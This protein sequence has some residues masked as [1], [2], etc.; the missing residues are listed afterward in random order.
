MMIHPGFVGID[1]CKHHL[2][3]FDTARGARRVENSA[4]CVEELAASF[5]EA[6]DFVLFE[7]TGSYDR[8]LCLALAA[9][10]VRHARVNPTRARA[11]AHAAGFLAKTDAVDARMLAAM[12]QALDPPCREAAEPERE[13]LARL[14]KRRDQLVAMRQMERTRRSECADAEIA[15]DLD[16]H[17]AVLDQAIAGLDAAIRALLAASAELA[18]AARLLRS[19]PGI[20]PVAAA[21]L[22]ALLPELGA[23][24]PKSIAAL[25]GVAPLNA[26]SGNSRG[27]RKIRGGRKRVRDALYMAAVAATRSD[28]AL[29]RFYRRLRQAGHAP[30]YALIA[31]ARK[32]LVVANAIL[33]DQVPFHA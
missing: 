28:T 15:A 1:V 4:E 24:S 33:R 27:K 17:L 16:R 12:A 31:L 2:D 21:T 6:G 11:F 25:V 26:D 7:A 23:R 19:V 30:K 10:G 32:L 22:L 9:A 14:G 8:A 13:R 18:R 20:G 29:A 3:I 5:A